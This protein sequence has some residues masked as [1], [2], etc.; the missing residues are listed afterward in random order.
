MCGISH[1]TLDVDVVAR[2]RRELWGVGVRREV[3]T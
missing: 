1:G 2:C 3:S